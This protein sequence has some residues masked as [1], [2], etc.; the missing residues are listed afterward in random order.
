M[1]AFC[2]RFKLFWYL[3]QEKERNQFFSVFYF[4]I[5]LGSFLSTI[6]TPFIRGK[7]LRSC[8]NFYKL[9]LTYTQYTF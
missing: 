9:C 2:L 8:T 7:A 6:V 5:N 1:A 4:A 3:L